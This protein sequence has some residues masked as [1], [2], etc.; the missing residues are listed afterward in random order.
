MSDSGLRTPAK[1]G[2]EYANPCRRGGSRADNR[3]DARVDRIMVEDLHIELTQM[4]ENAGRGLADLAMRRFAPD[5]VV[6]LA[7]PRGNGGGGPVT[8]RHLP[9]RGAAVSVVASSADH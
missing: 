3:P 2:S 7:G 8:A 9:N 4:M 1:V 5:S 6:V